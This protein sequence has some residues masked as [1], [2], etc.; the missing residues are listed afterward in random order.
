MALKR[1]A[2]CWAS[3]SRP[4]NPS[5]IVGSAGAA[6]KAANQQIEGPG[7]RGGDRPG[8]FDQE[9]QK[10]A[11]DPD[12]TTDQTGRLARAG[13]LL[14]EISDADELLNSVHAVLFKLPGG[15]RL[16]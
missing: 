14:D 4:A 10:A 9:R 6:L 12:S 11:R 8:K 13:E 5:R 3:R 16:P 1:L 2:N 15:A 7:P